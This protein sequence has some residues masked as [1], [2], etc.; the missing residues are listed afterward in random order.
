MI[1]VLAAF[2][3]LY[4]VAVDDSYSVGAWVKLR[5]PWGSIPL[6]LPRLSQFLANASTRAEDSSS[7]CSYL[8]FAPGHLP[9]IFV[10]GRLSGATCLSTA[11]QVQ[12]ATPHVC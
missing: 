5:G 4:L 9:R 12:A 11:C 3:Q 8:Q 6:S 10:N 7:E 2:Y 1:V